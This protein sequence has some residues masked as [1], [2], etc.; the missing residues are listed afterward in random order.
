M[1]DGSLFIDCNVVQHTRALEGHIQAK[2][3]IYSSVCLLLALIRH[4]NRME[5][6][7]E[8]I[9]LARSFMGPSKEA[10]DLLRHLSQFCGGSVRD[11]DLVLFLEVLSQPRNRLIRSWTALEWADELIRHDI[12]CVLGRRWPTSLSL[13]IFPLR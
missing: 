12:P 2:K 6:C 10:H 4:L 7:D 11:V 3:L 9:H 13:L 5:G 8:L 1:S